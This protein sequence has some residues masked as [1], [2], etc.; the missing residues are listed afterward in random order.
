MSKKSLKNEKEGKISRPGIKSIKG[1]LILLGAVSVIATLI[2]GMTGVYMVN[3]NNSNN[4]VLAGINTINLLQNSNQAAEVSFLYNLDAA[5]NDQIKQNLS[6]MKDAA[7]QSLKYAN[8]K[9]ASELQSISDSIDENVTNTDELIT[10]YNERGLGESDGL[11]ATYMTDDAGVC[12]AISAM[13]A[14]GE[15]VD[16]SWSEVPIDSMELVNIDGVNYRHYKYHTDMA[17]VGKRDYVVVRMG[18]NGFGYSGHIVLANV[19]LNN[20][21]VVDL[22]KLSVDDLSLSYGSGFK[23]LSVGKIGGEAC[24]E[25]DSTFDGTNS[26]WQEASIEIPVTSYPIEDTTEVSYDIYLVEKE[27]PV[28]KLALAYNE[29]YKFADKNDAL[30]SMFAQYTKKVAEGADASKEAGEIDALFSEIKNNVGTYVFDADIIAGAES[31]ISKKINTFNTIKEKDAEILA[32]KQQNIEINKGI[33][34]ITSSIRQDIEDAT[35]ASRT[36]MIILIVVVLGCSVLMIF[37]LTVFVIRSVQRSI[38]GF[39]TTLSGISEGNMAMKANTSAGD[40]FDVFGNSLNTMTDK[41]TD[42]LQ[43][44]MTI[45]SSVKQD[46]E[47]LKEMAQ[48][49][50][51]TSTQIRFS[52]SG[53]ADG[54]VEQAQ[55][56]EQSS[57]QINNLGGLMENLVGSVEGLDSNAVEMQKASEGAAEILEQLNASNHKMIDGVEKIA[58]QIQR[59]NVSVQEIREAVSLISSIASQTNLLSLNASIEA[60][61]AGEA[62]KGFAVVAT[63]I[64]QLADQSDKSA[65]TIDVIITN[66]TRDFE[67]TMSI[68]EDVKSATDEQLSKLEETKEQ[69]KIVDDGISA[70]REE[71]IMMKKA[72]T[73]CNDV[74]VGI[75]SNM[76]NLA[77]ISEENAASSAETA[78][79]MEKLNDTIN[80]LLE[81]SENLNKISEDLEENLN[82]FSF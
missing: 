45:A 58:E 66:L 7:A 13:D 64:Q 42:I 35:N 22:S 1:K 18:N 40:E 75:N 81:D 20:S 68:M 63:E 36:L 2:L 73:E 29:K 44:V 38:N 23:T 57:D 30:N 25:F 51:D 26:D 12:D 8:S 43:S 78:D 24:I 65:D 56:I 62:G 69:F 49:T 21:T 72:I 39:R 76:M 3:S 47:K 27:T 70:T 28:M 60:A 46:G 14:E 80:D 77:A 82:Y 5:Y 74:R 48:T 54:A 31:A 33:T 55:N 79:A 6:T 9:F 41:L 52:V 34:E 59:T 71:T 67:Q 10:L 50:S 17:S 61:R 16:G 53:I 37:I 32:L 19:T 4:E 11:Y 15:W